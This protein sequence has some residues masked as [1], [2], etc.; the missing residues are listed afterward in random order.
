VTDLIEKVGP[1]LG[2]VAFVGLAVLAFL[3]F[4]QAREVRRLREWAGRAPERAAEAAEASL[5]AADARGEAASEEEEEVPERGRLGRAWDGLR[6]WVEPRYAELDRRMPM[7]PRYLLVVLAAGLIAAGVVTSGFGVFDEEAG[8]GGGRAERAR[9]GA[10]GGRPEVTVLN[11]TQVE[12]ADG[13]EIQGVPMLAAKV[14]DQVVRPAGYAIA[15]TDDAASGTERTVVMYEPGAE[16]DAA[17]LAERVSDELG[18]T[19]TQPIVAEVAGL[20]GDAPLVLVVGLDD[21]DF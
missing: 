12:A 7:D 16:D 20:A 8:G 13:T 18:S 17:K 6:G 19:E 2:V 9:G 11:A 14:A 10:T 3:I 5:A 21:E 15:R 4:Q 1:L